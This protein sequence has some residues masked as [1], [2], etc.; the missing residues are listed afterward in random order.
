MPSYYFRSLLC[1]LLLPFALMSGQADAQPTAN[2]TDKQPRIRDKPFAVVE[3]FLTESSRSSRVPAENA[4]RMER[5]S[6]VTNDRLFVLVYHVDYLNTRGWRDPFG[7]PEFSERQE[8]YAA[9]FRHPR[10]EPTMTVINGSVYSPGNQYDLV[11]RNVNVAMRKKPKIGLEVHRRKGEGRSIQ[12]DFTAHGADRIRREFFLFHAAVIEGERLSTVQ[13]GANADYTFTH[14]NIVHHLASQRFDNDGRGSLE[15][16][17]PGPDVA[18][19]DRLGIIYFVQDPQT[20]EIWAA[21]RM[22]I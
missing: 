7:K 20:K 10:V 14:T 22:K 6:Q 9:E 13:A 16:L 3:Y 19:P 1:S 17:L 4:F 18:N 21:G 11:M 12:L 15:I 5:Q 2:P 8:M